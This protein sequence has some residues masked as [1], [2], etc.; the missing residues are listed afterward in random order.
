MAV[1]KSL[2]RGYHI[3]LG[4][5][6]SACLFKGRARIQTLA[7]ATLTFPFRAHSDTRVSSPTQRAEGA[8]S[9]AGENSQG[10]KR[11]CFGHCS[12]LAGSP[13]G[14][15]TGPNHVCPHVTLINCRGTGSHIAL[16]QMYSGL[17][18]CTPGGVRRKGDT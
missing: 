18:L 7:L 1:E 2:Y 16:G 11:S 8:G 6:K 9:P 4:K 13:Q 14:R 3:S 12:S 10:S 17:C 5:E 15:S